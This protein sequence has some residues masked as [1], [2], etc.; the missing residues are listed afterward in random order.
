[1][2]AELTKAIDIA[3]AITLAVAFRRDSEAKLT[4]IIW[5]PRHVM[6]AH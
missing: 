2:I 5:K 3:T 6:G 1:M 4:F